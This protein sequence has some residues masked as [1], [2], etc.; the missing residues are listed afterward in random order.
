MTVVVLVPWRP[1]PDREPLWEHVEAHLA[2]LGFP[3]HTGDSDTEIFSLARAFNQAADRPWD[4]AVL[5]E[6]DAW[7]PLDQIHQALQLDGLTYCFDRQIR[8]T[9]PETAEFLQHGTYPA[10]PFEEARSALG[11]NGVRVIT[12][13]LW[14]QLGGY[15]P[16]YI[17][18]GAEDYDFWWR[19]SHSGPVNRAE[20]PMWEL[21]HDRDDA[22]YEA[23]HRNRRLLA[24]V[25][26]P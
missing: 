10:R 26:N 20:G 12:R 8:F 1:A 9:V 16:R 5:S 19:A 4:A 6:A 24:E 21:S 13:D 11:S 2:G 15:D 23:R 22:Y 7:V 25:V 3:I 17:G 18:W 14:D